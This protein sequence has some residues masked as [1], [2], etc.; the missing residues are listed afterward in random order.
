MAIKPLFASIPPIGMTSFALK[1][2]APASTAHAN[3]ITVDINIETK[4]IQNT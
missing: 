2:M 1:S 3:G 4:E